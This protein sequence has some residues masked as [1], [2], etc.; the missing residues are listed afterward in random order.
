MAFA[1]AIHHNDA[2]ATLQDELSPE[3]ATQIVQKASTLQLMTK[4]PTVT[5][6]KLIIP[7]NSAAITADF[8]EGGTTDLG[9]N[10]PVSNAAWESVNMYMEKVGVI[11]PISVDDIEDSDFDLEAELVPAIAE[12]FAVKIDAA[13]IH[14]TAKPTNWPAGLYTT[15][16]AAS[17]V[18]SLAA[19]DDLYDAVLGATGLFSKMEAEGYL[20][21]GTIAAPTMKAAIRAA[22]DSMGV[23]IFNR[24]P[25]QGTG[26]EFDGES[27]LFDMLGAVASANSG[28]MIAGDWKQARWT[29]RKDMTFSILKEATLTNVAGDTTLSL[30][31]KDMVALKCVLRLGWALPNPINR[32]Q[33]TKASRCAFGLLLA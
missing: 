22:R 8:V 16:L 26:Y 19:F 33:P 20:V 13:I 11:V 23:P 12:A 17:N 31:Q 9:E 1:N 28:L 18:V 4:R 10:I 3:I 21:N 27:M 2:L 7:C 14:G 24:T 15:A 29:Y 25:G 30:A 5:T 6:K 32:V